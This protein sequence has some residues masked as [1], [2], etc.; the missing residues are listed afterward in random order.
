MIK[1]PQSKSQYASSVPTS[2]PYYMECREGSANKFWAIRRVSPRVLETAWGRIGTKGQTATTKAFPSNKAAI[3]AMAKKVKEKES[4]GY[5]HRDLPT[6][7]RSFSQS[8]KVIPE[9][10]STHGMVGEWDVL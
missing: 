3:V 6:P 5:I 9:L 10:P 8:T 7:L 2:G 4:K 1:R